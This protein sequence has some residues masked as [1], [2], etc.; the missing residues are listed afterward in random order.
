MAILSVI[1]N[2]RNLQKKLK[3]LYVLL[4]LVLVT[5]LFFYESK[6]EDA[7]FQEQTN[8][9]RT[10]GFEN[11]NKLIANIAHHKNSIQLFSELPSIQTYISTY[12]E[13]NQKSLPSNHTQKLKHDATRTLKTVLKQ[14]K[15]VRQARIILKSGIE[16]IRVERNGQ[17]LI[18]TPENLLQT[19]ENSQYFKMA[20]L[21]SKDQVYVSK[22]SPNYEYGIIEQPLWPTYRIIKTLKNENDI[23]LGLIVFNIDISSTL[24]TFNDIQTKT[25][26][27]SYLIDSNGYYLAAPNPAFLFGSDLNQKEMNWFEHTQQNTPLHAS[28][29]L[30]TRFI[31]LDY[32]F[33][34]NEISLSENSNHNYFFVTGMPKSKVRAIIQDQRTETFTLF[35]AFIVIIGIIIFFFLKHIKH[36]RSLYHDHSRFKA[37]VSSS[38]DAIISINKY[39]VILS[40]N[41]AATIL[42]G[43]S[44]PNAMG[45]CFFDFLEQ[46]TTHPFDDNFLDK[47]ISNSTNARIE[48][49]LKTRK[50]KKRILLLTLCPIEKK[51]SNTP[52]VALIIR[53][54]SYEK[55]N[56]NKLVTINR[57]L[58][59]QVKK[60]TEEI[61]AE[62]E[63]AQTANNLKSKFVANISH[64][65]R[66]P[67]NGITGLLALAR[68]KH[69]ASKQDD[70][71]KM[72]QESAQTLNILINDLLDFSKIESGK[73]EL[74][75]QPTNLIALLE[76]VIS[77][78]YFQIGQRKIELILDVSKV[79]DSIVKLDEH[80][81]RQILTNLLSNAIK[82]TSQGEVILSASTYR[83]NDNSA[84]VI[85]EFQIS[86][87][88]AGIPLEQQPKLFKPFT[89]ASSS[90][91]NKYGGTGLGLSI[92]KQLCEQMTGALT[93]E[94]NINEGSTFKA[95]IAS[96]EVN[97]TLPDANKPNDL[98]NLNIGVFVQN[99]QLRRVLRNQ[100]H[101]WKA[102]FIH[103]NDD[104]E[105]L[106]ASKTSTLNFA[107][108]DYQFFDA[109]QHK[110]FR[111]QSFKTIYLA[112]KDQNINHKYEL[113]TLSKPILP[114]QLL[115]VF[116]NK[117]I[118]TKS[119]PHAFKPDKTMTQSTQEHRDEKLLHQHVFIV[120]DNEI[121]RVVVKKLLS[122]LCE[123]IETANNGE[124]VLE[125]L[126]KLRP[127]DSFPIILMDCQMPII[128]GYT[129]TRLI[130]EGKAGAWLKDV[131]IIAMTA[132]A[133]TENQKDCKEA[134]MD[135]FIEKPI[136]PDKLKEKISFWSQKIT[137]SALP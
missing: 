2:N 106:N 19:K 89:Q 101:A 46:S 32:I 18:T 39:G 48:V 72:A 41:N 85:C 100:L 38:S 59:E 15:A 1:S 64:E 35:A 11:S 47:I 136:Y 109:Q 30:E 67:L 77:S 12:A 87:T 105:L 104:T 53:D 113:L 78:A 131:P 21:Q 96:E 54:I 95:V 126:K 40:W 111:G 3:F 119:T 83:S 116:S 20:K 36:L 97:S 107:L 27:E 94:S 42:F 33:S 130:R 90:I 108:I 44:E 65:I 117:Q 34:I 28:K 86:D 98:N 80:R 70:Y 88:G 17:E 122:Q 31:G 99:D 114:S 92:S 66:T 68:D 76:S 71:L 118:E 56:Q 60:R 134:G 110:Y 63:K 135:D 37:I 16:S 123:T 73:L 137:D 24:E 120:D 22:I 91:A 82:F 49:T 29:T 52:S 129:C 23:T 57:D 81:I 58:D 13:P 69:N 50:N 25:D 112:L 103:I 9:I 121:N 74:N 127:S 102:N 79:E 125:K 55:E 133:M 43:L 128:D 51:H 8:T 14:E 26:I 62:K 5:A 115:T 45:K 93:F 6:R 4:G 124:D 61:E 84:S 10:L 75:P 7:T 132:D